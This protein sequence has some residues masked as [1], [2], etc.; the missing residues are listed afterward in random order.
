MILFPLGHEHT[1]VRRLPWVTFTIMGLC[2]LVF[3]LTSIGSEDTDEVVL[4][5]LGEFFEYL[6]T[7]PYLEIDPRLEEVLFE[8][9]PEDEFH[10]YLEVLKEFTGPPPSSQRQVASEQ[11]HLDGLADQVLASLE[12]I[13]ESVY[14]RWGMVPA[15]MTPHTLIT[16]QFLHGGFWHLFGN[17]LFLF[18]AGPFIEDVWGRP[19]FATMYLAAGALAAFMYG[20]R[21]PDLDGPL[22][23]ASGAVAGVMGAF[24]IRYW[25]T[26]IRFFYF[27]FPFRPGTFM[28]PAWLMLPLWFLRELMFAQAMDVIAPRSG[29]GGVA[30][31]AHVW[32]F[33]VGLLAAVAIRYYRIEEKFIHRAIE[34]KITLVDNPIVEKAMDATSE[35][36]PDVALALLAEELQRNPDNVD[37]AVAMWNTARAVREPTKAAPHM[38]RV[39]QRAARSND[40]EL[41]LAHWQ[42][43]VHEVPDLPVDAAVVVRA[44]EILDAEERHEGVLATLEMAER[45]LTPET[46]SPLRIRLARV[47]ANARAPSAAAR[48]A[49]A[50]SQPDLP[51]EARA[52]LESLKPSAYELAEPDVATE[53]DVVA[54]PVEPVVM[55]SPS[56]HSLQVMEAVPRTLEGDVLIIDVDRAP[57][58]MGLAQ[59]QAVGVGGIQREGERPYLL[60]DLLL[61]PPWSERDRLRVV[62][63]SSTSFDPRR[64]VGGSDVM[65]AFR[66][67]LEHVLKIS[68]AVPLPDPE[69]AKGRPFRLFAS[70]DRYESEVLSAG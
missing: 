20:V 13:K 48:V 69:A 1:T 26:K 58:R 16:Y 55:N 44:A 34:S 3:I 63:L 43:L 35:G 30:H 24:L 11:D 8:Q 17:M 27:F 22:I 32:G 70:L 23:G 59:V 66:S 12:E 28:A 49:D 52:E 56:I 61:D 31:W 4:E 6:A 2:V 46:P 41:I 50:L 62:R 14:H 25:K 67:L 10:T 15:R 42:D 5:K 45:R 29:G 38:A 33:A 47:A 9:V 60:V 36:R 68:E 19:I 64:L 18:L 54:T 57:R 37:A 40:V 65:E 7:H 51:D 53:G 39:M 21:Y